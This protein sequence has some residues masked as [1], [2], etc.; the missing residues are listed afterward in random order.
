[1]SFSSLYYIWLCWYWYF[2]K[3]KLTLLDSLL[4]VP[5]DK[6]WDCRL[7]SCLAP[8]I[9]TSGCWASSASSFC[10]SA[11]QLTLQA[12]W[13]HLCLEHVC[14]CL[15]KTAETS[16]QHS[17]LQINTTLTQSFSSSLAASLYT[18]MAALCFPK[19]NLWKHFNFYFFLLWNP[20]VQPLSPLPVRNDAIC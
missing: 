4:L 14:S 20:A 12:A 1:M 8:A 11:L 5:Q 17:N 15:H 16:A 2:A 6:V 7:R 13:V 18:S 10:L 9:Q 3:L 19:R